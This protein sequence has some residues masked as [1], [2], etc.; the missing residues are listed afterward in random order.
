MCKNIKFVCFIREE[1][2]WWFLML[3]GLLG[4]CLGMLCFGVV[5]KLLEYEN[6][7]SFFL[8]LVG[9][10]VSI[11]KKIDFYLLSCEE[12]KLIILYDCVYR[13]FVKLNVFRV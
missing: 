12:M 1:N 4:F 11:M 9:I 3:I 8:K 7:L 10:F 6:S 5:M 13:C 2:V